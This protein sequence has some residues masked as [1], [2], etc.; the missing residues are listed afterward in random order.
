MKIFLP[1]GFFV[2]LLDFMTFSTAEI[3]KIAASFDIQNVR[4]R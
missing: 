1:L 2:G 3:P 4:S